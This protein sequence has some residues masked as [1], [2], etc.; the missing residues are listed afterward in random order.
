MLAYKTGGE[1]GR[2]GLSR[3]AYVRKQQTDADT[4]SHSSTNGREGAA[5]FSGISEDEE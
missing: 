2:L 1:G 3:A 5:E 4:Q